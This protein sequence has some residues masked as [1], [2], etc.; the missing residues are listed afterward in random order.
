MSGLCIYAAGFL[1]F[2][3]S[4]NEPVSMSTFKPVLHCGSH[5]GMSGLCIYAAG[6]LVFPEVLTNQSP[7]LI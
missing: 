2:P 4:I 3:G 7:C 6:F 5:C 1:V